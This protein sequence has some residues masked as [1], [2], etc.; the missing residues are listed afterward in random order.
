VGFKT[1]FPAIDSRAVIRKS[2]ELINTQ[3]IAPSESIKLFEV[4][5]NMY[6]CQEIN[7]LAMGFNFL[8]L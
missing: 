5:K 2:S 8:P 3:F 6:F 4:H 7:N 1:F